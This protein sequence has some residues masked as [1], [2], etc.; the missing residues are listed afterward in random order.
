MA[1]VTTIIRRCRA[2]CA[3]RLPGGAAVARRVFDVVVV[4]R[5]GAGGGVAC[6][7]PMP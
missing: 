5:Y 3:E 2:P 1:Y 4:R 7:P 6:N